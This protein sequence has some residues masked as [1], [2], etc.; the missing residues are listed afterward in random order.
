[1]SLYVGPC[2][3]GPLRRSFYRGASI[4]EASIEEF[5]GGAIV[6][7]HL[8]RSLFVGEALELL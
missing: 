6:E 5:S 3:E 1:M 4:G 2:I 7:E 8:C